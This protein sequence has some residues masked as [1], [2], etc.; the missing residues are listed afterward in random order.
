MLRKQE[1]M[2]YLKKDGGLGY[3]SSNTEE[4]SGWVG[5]TLVLCLVNGRFIVCSQIF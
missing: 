5:L 1:V 3:G 2:Q 4:G